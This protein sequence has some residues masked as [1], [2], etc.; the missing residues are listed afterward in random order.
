MSYS[1]Y[2]HIHHLQ[3]PI[4]IGKHQILNIVCVQTKG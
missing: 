1:D 2:Q 4:A 3:R